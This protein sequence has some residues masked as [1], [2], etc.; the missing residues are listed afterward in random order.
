MNLFESQINN[1]NLDQSMKKSVIELRKVC[2]ESDVGGMP[3]LD[4]E[5]QKA[6]AEKT[7]AAFNAI[8]DTI[9]LAMKEVGENLPSNVEGEALGQAVLKRI[10]DKYCPQFDKTYGDGWGQKLDMEAKKRLHKLALL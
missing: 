6:E 5:K 10:Q 2:L 7:R 1:L 3:N 4:F 9:N 8:K